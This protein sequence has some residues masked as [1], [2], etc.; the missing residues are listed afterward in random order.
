MLIRYIG[1]ARA[2]QIAAT[3]QNCPQGEPVDVADDLAE[4]LLAQS[5]WEAV[6]EVPE[7]DPENDEE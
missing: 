3:G 1:P 4:S 7:P 6:P 2:V 5:V